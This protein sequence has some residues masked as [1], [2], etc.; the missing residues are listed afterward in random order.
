[1]NYSYENFKEVIKNND[2]N[3]LKQLVETHPPLT[4]TTGSKDHKKIFKIFRKTITE[5]NMDALQILVK[6][7]ISLYNS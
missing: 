4:K 1:M 2:L 6:K 7:Q 5:N 3:S